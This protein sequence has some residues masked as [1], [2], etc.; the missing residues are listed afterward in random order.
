MSGGMAQ[1][2]ALPR[3]S[4]SGNRS[5]I[6][7]RAFG[8]KASGP[9]SMGDKS[10]LFEGRLRELLK[11]NPQLTGSSPSESAS[12]KESLE[13]LV[14]EFSQKLS[15]EGLS[16]HSELKGSA[17]FKAFQRDLS[18]F[19]GSQELNGSD[20]FDFIKSI[21]AHLAKIE[22]SLSP[23]SP[24]STK[25]LDPEIF[26]SN[27]LSSE[28]FT[29]EMNLIKN[30][31]GLIAEEI[32][33]RIEESHPDLIQKHGDFIKS[34]I[35]ELLKDKLEGFFDALKNPLEN[36]GQ[37]GFSRAAK[38][39]DWIGRLLTELKTRGVS[40]DQ[41]GELASKLKKIH[42]NG[43]HAN[44]LQLS[45][46][47]QPAGKKAEQ[48]G[49][50][51]SSEQWIQFRN[52][53]QSAQNPK[54]QN[55]AH[56]GNTSNQSHGDGSQALKES[57]EN[58][59][60]TQT[61][62]LNNKST[63]SVFLQKPTQVDQQAAMDQLKEQS[64]LLIKKGGGE[65]RLQLNPKHLGKVDLQVIVNKNNVQ[66]NLQ[67][68]SREVQNLLKEQLPELKANLG[69]QDLRLSKVDIGQLDQG[70]FRHQNRD[71]QQGSQ[72]ERREHESSR[73]SEQQPNPEEF[74]SEMSFEEA[75]AA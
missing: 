10:S 38:T 39:G 14:S 3:S 35:P 8:S 4:Q 25:S 68:E 37:K 72:H 2:F 13:K 6:V 24:G 53:S 31:L 71:D 50:G 7:E 36:L 46:N 41:L 62:S 55:N 27:F 19:L 64:Q 20:I 51:M 15:Q 63:P 56:L 44:Q 75:L 49:R 26:S 58:L 30:Q 22:E 59:F 43:I 34:R 33:K 65:M 29:S 16:N 61:A 23:S 21:E 17:L 66:V 52:G 69:A 1:L 12:L 54:A 67:A 18:R 9:D 11:N 60:S 74:A 57:F 42:Q 47:V 45:S 73:D 32:T 70:H 5:A 40:K 48:A 28:S